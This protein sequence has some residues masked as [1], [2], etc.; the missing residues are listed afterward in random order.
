[1]PEWGE[2]SEGRHRGAGPKKKR[3]DNLEKLRLVGVRGAKVLA[4]DQ[5]EE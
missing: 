3:F 5:K 1:L 4:L 2:E